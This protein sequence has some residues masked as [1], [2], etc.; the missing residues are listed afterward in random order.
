MRVT[1]VIG[2]AKRRI[3]LLVAGWL[4]G[5][6]A[7]AAETAPVARPALPARVSA[8]TRAVIER[9]WRLKTADSLTAALRLL[10]SRLTTAT[11]YPPDALALRA[12]LMRWNTERA[13]RN[14]HATEVVRLANQL[15]EPRWLGPAYY[16]LAEA[17]VEQQEPARALALLA[18]ALPALARHDSLDVTY[19]AALALGITAQLEQGHPAAARPWFKQGLALSRR[20]T[21]PMAAYLMLSAWGNGLRKTDPDSAR[22][23]LQRALQL[24]RSKLREHP[25]RH[26]IESHTQLVLMQVAYNQGRWQEAIALGK[27]TVVSARRVGN[28]HYELEALTTIAYSLREQGQ[29][30][31]AFDTLD[32]TTTI[33]E[34]LWNDNKTAELARQQ[35]LLGTVEQEA[36]IRALEQQRRISRLQTEQEHTRVVILLSIALG[37]AAL[38]ALSVWFY[39]RLARSQKA[40]TE[41]E[42]SLR[43][44]NATKE[45]LM[46][47]ISHDLLSPVA[48]IKQAMPLVLFYAKNPN[49]AELEEL[50]HDLSQQV[51]ELGSTIENLLFWSYGQSSSIR[52]APSSVDAGAILHTAVALYEHSASAK[53]VAIEVVIPPHLPLAWCDPALLATVLRNLISNAIKFT[54]A[55]GCVRAEINPAPTREPAL[56]FRITDT[57]IGMSAEQLARLFEM[58]GNRSTRGTAGESGTGLGLLVCWQ[59]TEMLGGRLSVVSEI[60]HGTTFDLQ[61][62]AMSDQAGLPHPANLAMAN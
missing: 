11:R 54:P 40:L 12:L 10:D 37:L 9:S 47:I 1:A 29:G 21:D 45:R 53:G 33:S 28:R 36:R 43:Q 34:E 35:A 50:T 7:F 46:S 56:H 25:R 27:Q 30:L 57:G 58:N 62:P 42:S 13:I 44:A 8:A 49:P 59:F 55:Q 16:F 22:H 6:Q 19:P 5:G 31:A 60:G 15:N 2:W 20:H 3:V 48:T 51:N 23:Y 17:A 38:L 14:R 52:N 26:I 39:R 32:R 18:H 4:L 41:S 24:T 61:V